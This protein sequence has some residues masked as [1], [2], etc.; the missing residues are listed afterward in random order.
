[1]L[2]TS[3]RWMHEA[4][5]LIHFSLLLLVCYNKAKKLHLETGER[6][7][8]T[9]ARKRCK[10]LKLWYAIPRL[11]RWIETPESLREQVAQRALY[12]FQID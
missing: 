12:D 10:L 9:S 8:I 11:H 2:V 5:L 3:W 4:I 7:L 6:I 1:M